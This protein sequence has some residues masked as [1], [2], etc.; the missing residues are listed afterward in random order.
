MN[1]VYRDLFYRFKKKVI[2]TN[3]LH[4]MIFVNQETY[5]KTILVNK[6]TYPISINYRSYY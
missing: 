2:K 5:K 3:Q 6:K 1:R 4:L